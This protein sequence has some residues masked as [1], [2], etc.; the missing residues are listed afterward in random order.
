M[1]TRKTILLGALLSFLFG[2][3]AS[4]ADQTD[5]SN[6]EDTTNCFLQQTEA[7]SGITESVNE[8]SCAENPDSTECFTQRNDKRLAEDGIFQDS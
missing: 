4:F 5:C 1:K 2:Q 6:V 3:Q 8:G 7:F